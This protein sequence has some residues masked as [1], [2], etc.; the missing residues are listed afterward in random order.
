[1][2]GASKTGRRQPEISRRGGDRFG[3][4]LGIALLLGLGVHAMGG[5]LHGR[6]SPD[7][8][9]EVAIIAGAAL[10]CLRRALSGR[11]GRA[12]WLL[13]GLAISSYAAS[14]L[15]L[16]FVDEATAERGL[17]SLTNIC[18]AGFYPL[19]GAAV[20]L[21]MRRRTG[22]IG[23]TFWLDGMIAGLAVL[24]VGSE[25]LFHQA[26]DYR[27]AVNLD[28][29]AFPVADVVLLGFLVGALGAGG[30]RVRRASLFPL[31]GLLVLTATDL[32]FLDQLSRESTRAGTLLDSGWPAAM[33]LIGLAAMGRESYGVQARP[34]T[35]WPSYAIPAL[36]A[37]IAAALLVHGAID[38]RPPSQ[39]LVLSGAVMV[40]V[41]ARLFLSLRETAAK[42]RQL[43]IT[44]DRYREIVETTSEGVWMV[45][46]DQ[47]TTFVNR[48][49]GEMLGYEIEEM[50]G[51][52]PGDFK[53]P[54][55]PEETSVALEERQRGSGGQMERVY[56]RKD[57]SRI[58]TLNSMSVIRSEDGSYQGALAMVTDASE[59]KADERRLEEGSRLLAEAQRLAQLGS[60]EWNLA[61]NSVLWSEETYRI[62]GLEEEGLRVSYDAYLERVHPGDRA[63][64]VSLLEE[65]QV[66]PEPF[67]YECRIVRPN[68]EVRVVETRGEPVLERGR[69]VTVVGTALDVTDRRGAE[70][71]I[72]HSQALSNSVIDSALDCVVIIDSDGRVTEFNPAAEATFGYTREQALGAELAELI[73]PPPLRARH[74]EGLAR[75][76]AS[77]DTKVLGR[78][79]ELEGMRADGTLFPVELAITRVSDD[80]PR[81]TGFLRDISKRKRSERELELRAEQQAAVATLGREALAE[82]DIQQLMEQAAGAVAG[83]LGV[84][85]AKVL[86]LSP[87]GNELVLR[88]AVGLPSVSV[89]VST[90]SA[91][92]HTQAG[93]T[94]ANQGPVIVEDLESET[95][96]DGATLLHDNGAVSGISVVIDGSHGA[97]GVIAGHSTR[98]RRFTV[99]ETHFMLSI[100]NV[101]AAAIGR[102]R[103]DRLELRL[104]RAQRLESVGQLAG[105]IAHDFN[106]LLSI[107]INYASFAI[108]ELDDHEQAREDVKEVEK[109]AKRAAV[110]TRQLLTFSRR[111]LVAPLVVDMNEL[112]TDTES[113]LR[114]TVG[115]HISFRM[116]LSPGLWR[117]K[118]G[119]TQFEHVLINLVL[120]ARDAMADGGELELRTDNV[121][122]DIP[123]VNSGFEIPPGRYA[124]LTVSDTGAGMAPEVVEHAFEP[125]YTTK[126]QGKGTGLG[127]ATV[128][129]TVKQADGFVNLY[130]E[131][132]SGTTLKIYLPAT[133]ADIEAPASEPPQEGLMGRGRRILLVEDE[134]AVR[135]VATRV[136]AGAGYTVVEASGGAQ[137]LT[138]MGT[139]GE[140]PFDL[141]LTDLAMPEMSGVQLAAEARGSYPS[142]RHLYMTGYSDEM[143]SRNGRLGWDSPVL[144]KPFNA[145]E[146]L[147][148]V[149]MAI[150]AEPAGDSQRLEEAM[151]NA[152]D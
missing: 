15:T 21:L 48:R 32:I 45:D 76:L 135:A 37:A 2:E 149:K 137:A 110:L 41:I 36:S 25:F 95:R 64:V 91:G 147:R 74:R 4:Y 85:F 75:V 139:D 123:I 151:A 112:V 52:P 70:D 93:Y 19:A 55:A 115:K 109:A 6:S 124:R 13:L 57:G 66:K 143:V 105:G 77:G 84:E 69:P 107:I 138:L 126:P 119:P 29:I 65:L 104:N 27:A 42:E 28:E 140:G 54:G 103:A 132:G 133:D 92:A 5:A 47:R 111:E 144:E 125:F 53:P 81:F 142:M 99:D 1:V 82:A 130:S 101:L 60:W 72:R 146:L 61:D 80:P 127:L 49:M 106:N 79:V 38:E 100:A 141:L 3:R 35:G 20:L 90:V 46:A 145:A 59:R 33:L 24:A 17:T 9:L 10:L 128:Y 94:L 51:R 58:W 97:Y 120:N 8:L 83:V 98:P 40:A 16:M 116:S 86:E 89:G 11:G 23:L 113:L 102:Q 78:R 108:Q 134:D 148:K 62:F 152:A 26:L 117:V 122:L 129:G 56:L 34:N 96:F 121:E 39:L 14:S 114:H 68:G 12:V 43:V 18:A 7:T 131:V 73:I 118:T 31:L 63:R 30:W 88:A 136:L 71:E 22:S 67:E 150:D 50:L 44:R 87:S